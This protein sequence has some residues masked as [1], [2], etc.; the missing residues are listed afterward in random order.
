MTSEGWAGISAEITGQGEIERL[1]AELV[2][3][4]AES[5]RWAGIVRRLLVQPEPGSWWHPEYRLGRWELL[6]DHYGDQVVA[7]RE[8]M[9]PADV[10]L[11][12]QALEHG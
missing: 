4:K 11:V 10:A 2:E 1:E 3:A 6:E 8:P 5:T 12:R 7:R 9:D